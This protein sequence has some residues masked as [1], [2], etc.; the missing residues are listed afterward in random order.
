M[1]S[2]HPLLKGALW[3]LG[4]HTKEMMAIG[5]MKPQGDRMPSYHM[6]LFPQILCMLRHKGQLDLNSSRACL[7]NTNAS[8]ASFY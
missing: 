1:L 2:E 6:H 5:R 3:I 7:A 8:L 4:H